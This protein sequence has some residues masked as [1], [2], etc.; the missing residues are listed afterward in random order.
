MATL[1]ISAAH[2]ASGAGPGGQPP[3]QQPGSHATDDL[4][5]FTDTS[6]S[7]SDKPKF[8]CK[9]CGPEVD[10]TTGKPTYKKFS[11][12]ANVRKHLEERHKIF[13]PKLPNQTTLQATWARVGQ[14]RRARKQAARQAALMRSTPQQPMANAQAPPAPAMQAQAIGPGARPYQNITPAP[15]SQANPQAE[16]MP[17]DPQLANFS[18]HIAAGSQQQTSRPSG[19]IGP[20]IDTQPAVTNHDVDHTNHQIGTGPL[21]QPRPASFSQQVAFPIA[22]DPELHPAWGTMAQMAARARHQ[23]DPNLDFNHE[24]GDDWDEQEDEIFA[25]SQRYTKKGKRVFYIFVQL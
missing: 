11:K 24:V 23:I 2:S 22:P 19:T 17:I 16:M 3:P 21:V 4:D 10:P 14:R 8:Y 13:R 6:D 15:H 25:D 20:Q 18:N 5:H 12:K 9:I 7:D 1:G